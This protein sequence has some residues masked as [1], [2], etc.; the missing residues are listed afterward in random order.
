MPSDSPPSSP[1]PTGWRLWWIAA[2]PRTLSLAVTP[3][4]AGS[5]LAWSEGAP[6]Q[7]LPALAALGSALLIQVG[8]NLHNDAADFES[9]NDQ[10]ERVGPVRVS[11]AGWIQPET[12]RRGA[13]F[14]F[15]L[16]LALGGY[17][18][19]VGGWPILLIGVFSLLAAWSY[20][21]GPHPISHTPLGELFVWLF[22]GLLA[23]AGSHYLQSGTLAP[24]ALV[25]GSA[26]GLL[27]AAVLMVNNS[28][29]RVGDIAAGRRTLAALLGP[30]RSRQAYAFMVLTPFLL[31]TLLVFGQPSRPGVLLTLLLLPAC[32]GLIRALRQVE[33]AALN[34][35]LADT[36]RTCFV[37]GLLLAIGVSLRI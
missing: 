20:S 12:V 23:V 8:T 5:A 6:H 31:A 35:V 36:A 32:L 29:D 37:F 25:A 2:R 18:V 10:P 13:L 28:R 22:F 14:A 21:G 30:R 9:G 1:I 11:A 34:A 26:L 27:A 24:S 15:G 17:L 4:L 3:V 7:W 16:A 33:G 19:Q